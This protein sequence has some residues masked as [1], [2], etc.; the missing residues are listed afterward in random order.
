MKYQ[1]L[2]H[3]SQFGFTTLELLLAAAIFLSLI[4][5]A[6]QFTVSSLSVQ[7]RESQEVELQQNVR[8]AM[9]LIAQ[10]IR[11]SNGLHLINSPNCQIGSPCSNSNQLS[12]ISASGEITLVR[13]PVNSSF[14]NSTQTRV[15][16]ARAYPNGSTAILMNATKNSVD[17][18]PL[19]ITGRQINRNLNQ[20][21]NFV[22]SDIINHNPVSGTWTD[23]SYISKAVVASYFLGPDPIDSSRTALYRR[24][25]LANQ[26]GQ[27][28]LVAFDITNLDIQ[29]GIA[30][31]A[32]L[33]FYPDLA[34]AA[35]ANPGW[36]DMPNSALPYIG[37]NVE[38]IKVSLTGETREAK[39]KTVVNGHAYYNRAQFS[40]SQTVELRR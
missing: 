39:V 35:A 16:D 26:G 22:N 23:R 2:S 12:T 19:D 37:N 3:H 10:D 24:T 8:A 21:C 38:I 14:S 40:L 13:E 32:N 27:S 33:T 30:A 15:C 18:S 17:S 28:G 11:S 5:V 36:S 1:R 34:T 9:Q 7:G 4:G 20:P 6:F 29:Y 31:G 25:G